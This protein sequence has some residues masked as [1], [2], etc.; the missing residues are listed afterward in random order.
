MFSASGAGPGG[1]FAVTLQDNFT[2]VD[3]TTT[4]RFVRSLS[5]ARLAG[6]TVFAAVLST[7]AV[8]FAPLANAATGTEF[9]GRASGEPAVL[10][11]EISKAE[12]FKQV[13]DGPQ[14]IAYQDSKTE[15]VFTF[16]RSGAGGAHPA[17]VCRRPVKDGE[18][19]TLEMV[20]ICRGAADACQRLESDFKLLN[21]QMEAHIR[22]QSGAAA[23][24]PK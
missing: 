4:P 23:N 6:T 15:T 14:Y 7:S 13:H 24:P 5:G 2:E 19:V 21:A 16:S 11:E 10:L 12:G 17:A 18:F 9:C 8:V 22:G 20:V 3:M 1:S